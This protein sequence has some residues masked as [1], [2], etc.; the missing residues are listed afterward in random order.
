[1]APGQRLALLLGGTAYLPANLG[2]ITHVVAALGI[3]LR[4]F[5]RATAAGAA[6]EGTDHR[7]AQQPAGD[8]R[9]WTTS[10]AGVEK[11]HRADPGDR[12]QDHQQ[13][14]EPLGQHLRQLR[15]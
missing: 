12:R 13:P 14:A 9:D 7:H 5:L 1:M 6:E 11:R 3:Q 4:L 8:V 10:A 2:Q 15:R